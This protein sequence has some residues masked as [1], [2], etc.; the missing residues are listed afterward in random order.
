VVAED[1]TVRKTPIRL[2]KV[3]DRE[4]EVLEGLTEGQDVVV[5]GKEQVVDGQPIDSYG[6]R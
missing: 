4:V 1:Q 3:L 5:Y 2:G 6:R